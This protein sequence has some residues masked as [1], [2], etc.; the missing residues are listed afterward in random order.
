MYEGYTNSGPGRLRVPEL[1]Q[2]N[3]PGFSLCAALL[4]SLNHRVLDFEVTQ[5]NHSGWNGS[6]EYSRLE[7]DREYLVSKRRLSRK[8]LVDI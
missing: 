2:T 6:P 1:T 5:Q 8:N 3:G 7:R 4:E